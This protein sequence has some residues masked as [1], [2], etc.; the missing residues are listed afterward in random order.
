MDR[1]S[2]RR[3]IVAVGI[4]IT[5][6][7]ALGWLGCS[8]DDPKP[9]GMAVVDPGGTFGAEVAVTVVGRGRVTGSIANGI[10]CPSRCYVRYTF[11]DSSAPG[12][13]AGLGLKAIATRGARFTGWTFE[14]EP[15]ATKGRD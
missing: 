4:S 11:T 6:I 14:T 2:T 13:A 5:P 15:L 9:T 8:D 7:A 1:L 12:A 10:D 3:T